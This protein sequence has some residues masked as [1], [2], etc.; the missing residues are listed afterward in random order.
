M[1]VVMTSET[2]HIKL[3]NTETWDYPVAW[4]VEHI[5]ADLK[6][7]LDALDKAELEW[8]AGVPEARKA[9][10][11]AIPPNTLFSDMP[12]DCVRMVFVGS[13]RA[14]YGGWEAQ[15]ANASAARWQAIT[16]LT[17]WTLGPP[18]FVLALG[19]SLIWAFA[20]F[21]PASKASR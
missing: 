12:K 2:V 11:H 3:S 7:R 9:E 19:L 18:L 17:L 6:R 20:G 13:K 15:V 5:E 21:R 16:Q 14:V 4:G 8:F 10:C 1:D